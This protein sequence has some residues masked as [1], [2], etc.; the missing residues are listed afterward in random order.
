MTK[1]TTTFS[2]ITA[3]LGGIIVALSLYYFF[4][5]ST[6]SGGVFDKEKAAAARDLFEI[7]VTRTLLPIFNVLIAAILT[8]VFGKPLFESLAERIRISRPQ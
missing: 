6:L 7:V 5:F 1:G 8:W 3:V 4:S 2:V